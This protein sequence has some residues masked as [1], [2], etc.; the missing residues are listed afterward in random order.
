MSLPEVGATALQGIRVL[1][2]TQFEAGPACTQLLAWLGADVVKVERPGTGEQGRNASVDVLG[3]DSRYFLMLN[4][5]KRSVTL[6][7]SCEAGAGLMR[8]LVGSADVMVENFAPGTIDRLGFGYEVAQAIN[9]RIVYAQLKGFGADGPYADLLAFDP[10]AQAAGGAV[11]V[12]GEP[13]GRPLKPGPTIG[14]SGA[15]LSC[16]IGILAALYQREATGHGQRVEVAM[17][18]AV[19]NLCRIAYARQAMT[20][21]AAERYGNSSQLGST[22]PSEV[23]PCMGGGPN[24]YCYVYTTRANNRHWEKLLEIIGHPELV[25]EPTFS[26]PESRF[27]HRDTID[28][29]ITA[30]TITRPKL[31]VMDILGRAGV[32]ASAVFDTLELSAD[33]YLRKRGTFIEVDHPQRGQ[34]VMP[35]S[36]VRLS[37]SDVAPV[38][39]PLLGQHTAEVYREW[40]GLSD[41]ELAQAKR[42]G[43]T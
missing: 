13:N 40:L 43:V 10:I 36:P 27:E 38:A 33:P 39:A 20:G 8:R 16:A 24:D 31:E 11:S 2:L 28:A 30:W 22:G 42:D 34:F 19:I 21:R 37:N 32:P 41:T 23:Y 29:L 17:Q 6:D 1:D 15:G 35:G 14:D 25:G 26:S 9:P 4:A 18:D 5:N 3:M 12:T 7:L